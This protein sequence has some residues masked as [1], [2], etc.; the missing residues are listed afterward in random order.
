ME[1]RIEEIVAEVTIETLERLAFIFAST[2]DDFEPLEPDEAEFA[3][4]SFTGPISGALVLAI[5][6]IALPEFAANMLGVDDEDD[7]NSRPETRH[8][9]RILEYHLR[10]SAAGNFRQASGF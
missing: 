2:E 10:Q 6:K 7:V 5:S 1:S 8:V 3:K 4:V 9:K